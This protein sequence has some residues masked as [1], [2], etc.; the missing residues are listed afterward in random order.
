MA[1][2][3]NA[4]FGVALFITGRVPGR[5]LQTLGIRIYKCAYNRISHDYAT[6]IVDIGSYIQFLIS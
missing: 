1:T 4:F 3:F 5:Y 2:C 6:T